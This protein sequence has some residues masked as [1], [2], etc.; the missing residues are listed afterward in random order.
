MLWDCGSLCVKR[1]ITIPIL[2]RTR[3]TINLP[4]ISERYSERFINEKLNMK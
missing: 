1:K 4:I 3:T 2:I